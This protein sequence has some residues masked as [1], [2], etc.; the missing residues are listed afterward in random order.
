M[1]ADSLLDRLRVLVAALPADVSLIN[2]NDAA[3]EGTPTATFKQ[4]T[5]AASGGEPA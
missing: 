5:I 1:R 4:F 2:F 3:A